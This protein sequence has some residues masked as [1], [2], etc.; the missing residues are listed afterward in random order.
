MFWH[1]F[2]YFLG[3]YQPVTDMQGKPIV[4]KYDIRANVLA[5]FEWYNGYTMIVYCSGYFKYVQGLR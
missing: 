2:K 1:C 5:K 4:H 3:A